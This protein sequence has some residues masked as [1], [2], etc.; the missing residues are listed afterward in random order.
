MV[1]RYYMTR[2][3]GDE[4]GRTCDDTLACWAAERLLSGDSYGTVDLCYFG[5]V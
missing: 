2:M 4:K 5:R 3:F 1:V